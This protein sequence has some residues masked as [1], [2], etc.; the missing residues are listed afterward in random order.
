MIKKYICLPYR[1]THYKIITDCK[2]LIRDIGLLY[3]QY[4]HNESDRNFIE[5]NIL[6]K[7]RN[8]Y[9]FIYADKTL[10]T[11]N[12]LQLIKNILFENPFFSSEV[13]AFHGAAIEHD[14]KA[15]VFLAPTTSG[16]T[17][18]TSYLTNKGFNYI[19]DDCVIINKNNYNIIPSIT[20]IHLR[21]GG[22]QVLKSYRCE[23]DSIC[24]INNKT[25]KRYVYNPTN[26]ILCPTPIKNIFFLYR[27]KN[28]N[29]I[30]NIKTPETT[31][32]LIKSL[33]TTNQITFEHIKTVSKLSSINCKKV[34]YN[35]M[36]YIYNYICKE[37]EH[38][39]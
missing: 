8:M 10:F 21:E 27:N 16:K 34:F 19:T 35:D 12:P 15:Y 17:T 28:E 22:L 24:Y 26:Y 23:P 32:M 1:T 3:G 38:E 9:I 29:K 39:Q 7:D 6:K 13:I 2:R 4:L 36:D 18:L 37:S 11:D 20:P 31:T 25:I 30:I 33:I 14:G 5:I